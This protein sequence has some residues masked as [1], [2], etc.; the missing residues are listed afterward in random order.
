MSVRADRFVVQRV[1]NNNVVLALDGSDR[2]VVITGPGVGFGMSRGTVLDPGRIETVYV[3]E[4]AAR[5][6]IAADTLAA[7]PVP[8]LETAAAIV[9]AFD[10]SAGLTH[11]D[12]LLVPVADHLHQAVRRAEQGIEIEM[13]LVWEV[14]NL[15]PR[16][17]RIGQE[18]LEIIAER[19]GTRLPSQE[20]TAFAL[21]FVS[22]SFSQKVIDRTVLMTQSLT[23]IFSRIDAYRGEPLDRQGAAAARFVTHLR[24]LFTRLAEGR[25]VADAPALLHDALETGL[26]D[27]MRIARDISALL[28]ESWGHTLSSSESAYIALHVH[29]LLAEAGDSPSS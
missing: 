12:V 18:A 20:A 22:V 26:P 25:E 13:P 1:H 29:R 24:Y 6:Q 23:E 4:N 27:A 3:P 7:I 15:Y 16:E 5:A 17:T 10:H 28:E 21:H 11:S 8:V 2:S 14:R 19:L 9:D